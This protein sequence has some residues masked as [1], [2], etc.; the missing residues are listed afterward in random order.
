MI[1]LRN[2]ADIIRQH[3]LSVGDKMRD[4][5]GY[6]V[7]RSVVLSA[8]ACA[9]VV[10]DTTVYIHQYHRGLGGIRQDKIELPIE[11]FKALMGSQITEGL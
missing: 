5:S 3:N 2:I 7:D 11:S 9:H 4:I 10:D 1:S 6:E 8:T